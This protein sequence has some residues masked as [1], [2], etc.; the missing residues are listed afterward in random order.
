MSEVIWHNSEIYR[1]EWFQGCFENPDCEIHALIKA[2][3]LD[4]N[5]SICPEKFRDTLNNIIDDSVRFQ[6]EG[7]RRKGDTNNCCHR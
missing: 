4:P 5:E 6:I 2:T 3:K 7:L 1:R